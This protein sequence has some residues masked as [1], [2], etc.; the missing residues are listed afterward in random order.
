MKC[1]VYRDL[2]VIRIFW[3]LTH[4]SESRLFV[5][6]W[7]PPPPFFTNYIYLRYLKTDHPAKK[8]ST[9]PGIFLHPTPGISA[10]HRRWSFPPFRH[11]TW[12]KSLTKS[13]AAKHSTAT[14]PQPPTVVFG[15]W[16]DPGKNT[17]W[18][19]AKTNMFF[20]TQ[21]MGKKSPFFK[22]WW[23]TCVEALEF[24]VST[25]F[26]GDLSCVQPIGV[27]EW[28]FSFYFGNQRWKT[29]GNTSHGFAKTVRS[30]ETHESK[31]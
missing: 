27:F 11:A 14:R 12:R 15:S 6:F 22:W 28:V 9:T 4:L 31:M 8:N 30:R 7:Q 21:E 17:N 5:G 26:F 16:I 10:L 24:L 25:D 13:M 19:K 2:G 23:K 1:R 18:G 20:Y 29:L 3:C